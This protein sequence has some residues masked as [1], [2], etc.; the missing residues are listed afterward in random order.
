MNDSSNLLSS[1]EEDLDQE[2][3][4]CLTGV[5]SGALGGQVSSPS[6]GSFISARI[7]SDDDTNSFYSMA[8]ERTTTNDDGQSYYSGRTMV[9]DF[10]TMSYQSVD[11]LTHCDDSD[12]DSTASTGDICSSQNL[13]ETVIPN[14]SNDT[15]DGHVSNT[16]VSSL[17]VSSESLT[18]DS[19]VDTSSVISLAGQLNRR[20]GHLLGY[21]EA[22][23]S[24]QLLSSC[25]DALA[26]ITGYEIVCLRDNSK[27]TI[28]KI[29]VT[30][31][32]SLLGVWYIHRRYS[33]FW[34]LRKTL[35][36]EFPCVSGFAFPP[37]RYVGSNL[38][39]T[40]LGRRLSCLQVFLSSVLGL[41]EVC[42][43]PSLITFLCLSTPAP[44]HSD[45]VI[46]Q[47]NRAVCE[48][49]EEAVKELRDQLKKREKVEKENEKLKDQNFEKDQ[50]IVSLKKENLLLKQQKES[51]MTALSNSRRRGQN[52]S[53]ENKS[54]ERNLRIETLEDFTARF[55]LK[56][57]EKISAS[58]NSSTRSSTLDQ[59]DQSR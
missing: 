13:D 3:E 37:K 56:S 10:D 38:D 15:G 43:H 28:Y 27:Y 26:N 49:L 50:E 55:S 4:S 52:F 2:V 20:L 41:K 31:P 21:S 11:T 19:G 18:S 47:H 46:S 6:S 30:C 17:H 54:E 40:F 5:R 29:R 9:S 24:Q 35:L 32:S 12:T 7:G 14:T 16:H 53:K 34:T 59:E 8:T 33:D 44:T 1:D 39:P 36:K 42:N 57:H 51:L 48:S 25:D 58:P 23:S 45:D 22:S